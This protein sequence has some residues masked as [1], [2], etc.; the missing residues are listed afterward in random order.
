M[1]SASPPAAG[2]VDPPGGIAALQQSPFN[3]LGAYND[4]ASGVS[5]TR[6]RHVERQHRNFGEFKV[7]GLRQTG[8]AGPYMH[9][10]SLA[11]LEEVVKHYS[12]V[13]PDRLHSD[14]VPLVRALRLSDQEGADLVA[15]LRTLEADTPRLSPAP[16]LCSRT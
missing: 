3:R 10:G 12:E 11:T 1:T 16:V 13:S 14:G 9:A 7:P 4:D 6:T 15:F 8:R 5:A 2:G